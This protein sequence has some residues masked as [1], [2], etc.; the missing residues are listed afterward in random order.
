MTTGKYKSLFVACF[1]FLFAISMCFTSLVDTVWAGATDDDP[2]D[3]MA[4]SQAAAKSGHADE[5]QGV[6]ANPETFEKN[7][8][9]TVADKQWTIKKIEQVV[10]MCTDPEM[11]DLQKYYE[12]GKWANSRVVYDSVFWDGAYNFDYYRHQWDAYGCMNED[13]KSVCAG[14]AIF[15]A[16]LCHAADLPCKFARLNPEIL[17]HTITY[18]PDINGNA[19]YADITENQFL[20]SKRANPFAD[21]V[22][23]EFAGITKDAEDGTFEYQS[24][25][26][27]DF[28][29]Y[30]ATDMKE[31]WQDKIS[32]T[33]WFNEFALH[34]DK[35][36][37]FG[38]DYHELG[39]GEAGTHY[40]SYSDFDNYP[41]QTYSNLDREVTGNW[42][43]D[44]FYE[45]PT[46]AWSMIEN[47]EL[48]EQFLDIKGVE[49]NYN[50]E[51]TDELAAA[52]KE[53]ISISYFPTFENGDVVAKAAKLNKD[54]DYTIEYVGHD[55]ETGEE[56]LRIKEGTG[57]YTGECE[58]RV[59]MNSAVVT[60]DPERILGLAYNGKAQKLVKAGEAANGTMLYA[61]CKARKDPNEPAGLDYSE[62]IP[63][64]T[65]VGK[66]DIWYKVASVDEEQYH[67]APSQRLKRPLTDTPSVTI[68]G[69]DIDELI[70]FSKTTFTYNGE[71]QRPEIIAKNLK[72]G[73]DYKVTWQNKSSKKAG[74][75]TVYIV[76]IGN[77]GGEMWE[78]YIIN[79]AANPLTLK[80]KTKTVKYS[81]VKKEAQKIKRADVVKVSKGKG[82]ETYKLVS[83]KKDKKSFKKKFKINSK[84]GNVTVKKGL[85]KGTYKVKVKVK[86]SGNTNYKASKWKKV[87]FTIVVK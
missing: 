59:Y 26:S 51:T 74:T 16:N 45:K 54:E 66:Y 78:D 73:K 84:N 40:A 4:M 30:T 46:V 48:D 49:K 35:K 2:V 13:E 56:I 68:A 24:N 3:M 70:K 17:D 33:A 63:T 38:A 6:H 22:D 75:Y 41:A 21:E 67:P 8:C 86:S 20:A 47:K 85:K 11:S 12:L 31:C 81:K 79:K 60:T 44:D 43:L 55:D 29:Y 77:Y 65:N 50:C 83:A 52:V 14:I 82:D 57:E 23:K 76:G 18:I 53:G 28:E 71:V 7:F 37:K 62:A 34:K 39:S 5:G 64:A 72:E 27:D 15:Y 25:Y 58:L 87:T 19:Y 9:L 1:S 61:V 42:I 36:K 80:G 32:Y 69:K 10:T